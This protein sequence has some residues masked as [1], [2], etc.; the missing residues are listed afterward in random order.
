M[1]LIIYFILLQFACPIIG[2]AYELQEQLFHSPSKVTSHRALMAS[3]SGISTLYFQDIGFSFSGIPYVTFQSRAIGGEMVFLSFQND[4][5]QI[6]RSIDTKYSYSIEK[7]STSQ[8]GLVSWLVTY[9]IDN[10]RDILT[11]RDNLV[12][13]KYCE[14]AGFNSIFDFDP[15]EIFEL[16]PFWESELVETYWRNTLLGWVY[17][18]Q[19]NTFWYHTDTLGWCYVVNSSISKEHLRIIFYS[20]LNGQWYFTSKF[21]SPFV[22]SF[23]DQSWIDISG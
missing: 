18:P 23:S 6:T 15:H 10:L 12:D 20:N 11:F 22:Y 17:H 4:L 8:K 7:R 19:I 21:Y 2:T 9:D 1:K 3:S 13:S 14:S 16:H 5:E